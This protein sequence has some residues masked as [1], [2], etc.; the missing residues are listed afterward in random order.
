MAMKAVRKY[1]TTRSYPMTDGEVQMIESLAKVRKISKQEVVFAA[2]ELLYAQHADQAEVQQAVDSGNTETRPVT[3]PE[4]HAE[5]R[6]VIAVA[7]A[8]KKSP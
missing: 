7:G 2:I 4:C 6:V 3:C 5:L 8:T 1:D